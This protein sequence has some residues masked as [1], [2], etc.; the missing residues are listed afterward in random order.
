MRC[1]HTH[2]SRPVSRPYSASLALS[3]IRTVPKPLEGH[4]APQRNYVARSHT[5]VALP[6]NR[7]N[8][9]AF[10]PYVLNSSAPITRTGVRHS[11]SISITFL[12]HCCTYVRVCH[13]ANAQT[14]PSV[15]LSLSSSKFFIPCLTRGFALTAPVYVRTLP[16][17]VDS[18]RSVLLVGRGNGS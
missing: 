5:I 7:R 6:C 3:L 1:H 13:T 14:R 16:H 8:S 9:V 10:R 11:H 2:V 12:H 17:G 4:T 18:R 15:R